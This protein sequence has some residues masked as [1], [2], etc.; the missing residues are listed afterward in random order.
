MLKQKLEFY[1]FPNS[2]EKIW[3]NLWIF[4]LS[5]SWK[6]SLFWEKS[7]NSKFLQILRKKCRILKKKVQILRK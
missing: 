7:Q 2:E 5:E 4:F 6:F 1:I 3:E